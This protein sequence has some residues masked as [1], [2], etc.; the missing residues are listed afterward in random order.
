MW[1]GILLLVLLNGY[2]GGLRSALIV[3]ATIRSRCFSPSSPW[4]G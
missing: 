1:V 4:C 3:G 2:S